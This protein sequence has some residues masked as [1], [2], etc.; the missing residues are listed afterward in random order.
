MDRYKSVE[1]VLKAIIQLAKEHRERMKCWLNEFEIDKKPNLDG[2]TFK[3]SDIVKVTRLNEKTV[4]FVLKM[5]ERA[6]ILKKYRKHWFF[7]PE[8]LKLFR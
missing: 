8:F 1:L 3:N 4:Y 2:F 7:N 5:L 6:G